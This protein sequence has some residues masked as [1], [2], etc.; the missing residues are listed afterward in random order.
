MVY[1]YTYMCMHVRIYYMLLDL[2]MYITRKSEK[3]SNLI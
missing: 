1:R 3:P 2:I